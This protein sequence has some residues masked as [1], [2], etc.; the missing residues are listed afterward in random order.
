MKTLIIAE[1]AATH[2]GDLE[3]ALCLVNLA[4]N[5]GAS[6]VKFQ[7]LS[8]PERLAERRHAPEYLDAYR[9]LAFPCEWFPVLRDH[10]KALGLEFLCTSY[11]PEDVPVVAEYV[12]R[13]KV[14]SFEAMDAEFVAMHARWP[15]TPL[16]ISAGMGADV[17]PALA[18]YRALRDALSGERV[19][20]PQP[21]ILACTSAYPCPGEAACLA[22]LHPVTS[23]Y[24]ESDI[25][26]SS[27][28]GYS[29][30]TRH[31]W[32]GAMAVAAG[33]R[34]IEFHVRLDDTSPTNADYAVARTP[35][36]ACEYVRHIREAEAM[37]GS[38]ENRIQPSES[39]MLRYRVGGVS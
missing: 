9:L 4:A 17:E 15:R 22:R 16:V 8:S 19:G 29:D 34:I 18:V 32:T 26:P 6:A 7:W 11:L 27:Y 10:A 1:A 30:H 37:L 14:S 5:V 21:D 12:D 33:A 25:W 39:A 24:P 31:P 28:T 38:G 20:W 13:F 2:D 3:Q 36:E 35:D 23:P